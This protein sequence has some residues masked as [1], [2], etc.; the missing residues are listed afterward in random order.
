MNTNRVLHTLV[1]EYHKQVLKGGL[2]CY[3]WEE[4][5]RR[6]IL[7]IIDMFKTCNVEGVIYPPLSGFDVIVVRD[8][9]KEANIVIKF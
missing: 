3:K 6:D 5:K 9:L 7:A 4:K 8:M 1:N 2:L